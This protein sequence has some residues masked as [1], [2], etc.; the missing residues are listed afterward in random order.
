[1]VSDNWL[2]IAGTR[3]GPQTPRFVANHHLTQ[4]LAEV[5][6]IQLI[7]GVGL[8]IMVCSTVLLAE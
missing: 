7:F 1:M 2:S 5:G 4:Q 3:V 6:E 8:Q